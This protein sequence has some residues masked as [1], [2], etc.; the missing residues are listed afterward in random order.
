MIA[1]RARSIEVAGA[2]PE[3]VRRTA[4]ELGLAGLC[5]PE[6]CG[7]QGQGVVTGVLV[8]EEL[9]RA[10]AQPHSG[11]GPGA[12]G[13]ALVELGT[14]EQASA[15]LAPSSRARGTIATGPSPGAKRGRAPTARHVHDGGARRRRLPLDGEKCFVQHA[16]H[17]ASFVVF[18][19]G[20]AAVGWRGLGA[21]VVERG[22]SGF[23]VGAR[24]RT[25]GLDCASFGE[26]KLS[27]VHVAAGGAA[28]AGGGVRRGDAAVLRQALAR[29]GGAR[30]RP[31][32]QRVRAGAHL[33]RHAHRLRQ[34]HRPFQAVAFNL[35]IG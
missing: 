7:G 32:P 13:T 9:G 2:V 12:F 1:P 33:L 16:E 29:G 25:L 21:F 5:L 8:E 18:G 14:A 26:V 6:A 3:D 35:A 34:A 31:R 30:G 22:A 10:D 15:A 27:G 17:A 24:H 23:G 19:A 20:G 11:C 28:R 4:F